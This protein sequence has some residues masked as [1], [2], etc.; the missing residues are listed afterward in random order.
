MTTLSVLIAT[1]PERKGK[2]RLLLKDL[3][4]QAEGL[5]VEILVDDRPKGE[6]SIGSKRQALLERA[7]GNYIC[8][9]DDDDWHSGDYL[10]RLVEAANK[11]PDCIGFHVRV[12][13]M[14]RSSNGAGSDKLASCSNQWE[15]WGEN[16]GGFDYVRTIYHKTPVLREYA[17]KIGF[18]D[19]RFAEDHDYSLRLKVSGL[20][21][22]EEYV[23]H[24]LYIYRFKREPFRRKYGI[25]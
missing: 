14:G 3:Q 15:A 17:L 1:I 21:R 4:K 19:M 11:A 22:V 24:P 20:L 10:S 16:V 7:T 23:P 18:K 5:A 6:L 13:G 9:H 2:F 12:V 8:Y 25:T